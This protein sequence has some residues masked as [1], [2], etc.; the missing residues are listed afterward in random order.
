VGGRCS[1]RLPRIVVQTTIPNPLEVSVDFSTSPPHSGGMLKST[2]ELL[3]TQREQ[4]ASLAGIVRAMM[5]A[6][7][8]EPDQISAL[9][10]RIEELD[11]GNA[12]WQAECEATLM[13]ATGQYNSARNAE[14]RTKTMVNHESGDG[15]VASEE[16]VFQA[17][18]ALGLGVSPG[19]AEA[20]QA[21][22]V[23]QMREAVEVSFKEQALRMKF[24]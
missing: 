15:S 12:K 16:E 9:Q 4:A 14:E 5:L 17:Y 22:E 10:A 23:Q 7:E 11:L 24:S 13:K 20:G 1:F 19:D 3:A 21:E 2:R 18:R 8:G 6:R